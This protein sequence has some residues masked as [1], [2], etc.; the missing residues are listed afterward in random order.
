MWKPAGPE[1]DASHSVADAVCD[2]L[3]RRVAARIAS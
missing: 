1:G 2:A 3:E